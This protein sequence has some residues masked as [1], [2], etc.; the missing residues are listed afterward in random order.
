MSQLLMHSLSEIEVE[1][2]HQTALEVL[3]NV[4]VR[5]EHE[6]SL[7]KLANAG[8]LVDFGSSLVRLPAKMVSEAVSIA[9]KI[10]DLHRPDGEI[11]HVG[12][13]SRHYGSIVT[14][15]Y[16]LDYYEG[17]RRPRLADIV[18]HTR[19]G[20]ALPLISFMYRME[21]S[22]SDVPDALVNLKTM[23][24]F[25]CNTTKHMLVFPASTDS[26][27]LL[28]EMGEIVAGGKSL[29]ENPILTIGVPLT[30]P[31]YLAHDCGEML[32]LSVAKGLPITCIVCPQAGATSP[33]SIAGT[34]MQAHAENLFLI[35]LVQ[36]LKPGAPVLYRSDPSNIHR[37]TGNNYYCPP[38]RPLYRLAANELGC[39]LGLPRE[40]GFGTTAVHR[41]D[42]QNG[43]E[44]ALVALGSLVGKQ[45]LLHAL[46]SNSNANG[47]CAEQILI[48]VELAGMLERLERGIRVDSETLAY[49]S[50]EQ[51][52]PRGNFLTDDL[53]IK[54][55]RSEEHH[56]GELLDSLESWRNEDSLLERAHRKVDEILA[57]HQPRVPER[58]IQ[59]VERYVIHKER[60]ILQGKI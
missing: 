4:G 20:D 8:A 3:E 33:F 56:Y 14:D 53:T 17:P 32:E 34:L 31:L 10:I 15:P 36:V 11:L 40:G 58:T 26:A 27:R 19:L 7:K 21:M 23:E 35:T 47:M 57:S 39:F 54:L 6:A 30:S 12:G 51:A 29:A 37:K 18:K 9:P 28:I 43:M 16:I 52:G 55:L 50:I 24:A 41:M 2:I 49:K 25:V 38:E 45:N 42:I 48:H 59:E 5:V 60:E 13:D 1:Q 46:G 22:C 44:N